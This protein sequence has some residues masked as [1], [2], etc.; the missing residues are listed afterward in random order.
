MMTDEQ[1]AAAAQGGDSAATQALLEKYKD[2]VRG[3]AR[4][5]FL[6]GGDGEDLVQEG[7]IGLYLAITGFKAGGMSFKNFAYVCIR[8]RI[9]SAVK[10]A[11]RKKHMPLNT[12]IPFPE[13]GALGE[14]AAEGDPEEALILSE[15]PKE[16]WRAAKK[17]LSPAELDTL[18]LYVQGVSVADIAAKRG[19]SAKSADN[20]V[21]R[22]KRKIAAL[23]G[24]R[25][26]AEHAVQK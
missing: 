4:S 26:R 22:A 19:V 23:C 5:F 10:S 6:A 11:A 12:G 17:V 3:A 21:Q 25:Q 20:A 2:A 7:M 18:L 8:R 13:A 9:M 24:Q 16:F 14:L 1:L 15:E